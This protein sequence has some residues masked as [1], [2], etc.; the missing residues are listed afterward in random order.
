MSLLGDIFGVIAN[1]IGSIASSLISGLSGSSA[2]ASANE[3]NL[4]AARETNEA[5]KEIHAA[6][7]AFNAEQ[8]QIA[9]EWD[10]PAAKRKRLEEAGYNPMTFGEAANSGVSA[11]S[12]SAIP[13]TTGAPVQPVTAMSNALGNMNLDISGGLNA[14]KEREQ[15]SSNIESQRLERKLAL[16]DNI[17]KWTEVYNRAENDSIQ[18]K[19]A[20]VQV[21]RN[22]R[23]MKYLERR[24]ESNIR[25]LD[26][27]YGLKIE[28]IQNEKVSR[29]V[30]KLQIP[31][32]Q[33]AIQVNYAQVKSLIAQAYQA[34]QQG[35]AAKAQK[36][37]TQSLTK[38][39]DA[40]RDGKVKDQILK[41]GYAAII[42]QNA[43]ADLEY[44]ERPIF[45]DYDFSNWTHRDTQHFIDLLRN[46][47][48]SINPLGGAASSAVSTGA[49]LLK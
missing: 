35:D 1:P 21:E 29:E 19:L 25:L 18:R 26:A 44:N 42:Y 37:L 2:Q 30:A 4:Q 5:N 23:E 12:A 43:A 7:N 6:D 13:M 40:L 22:Q 11:S 8:A 28:Q 41:N 36:L 49:M 39:E 46:T 31:L 17:R 24:E 15:V 32:T 38:T 45:S 20:Q 9:R 27:E 10:T 16:E 33:A 3:A 34:Y 47:L 14:L 48:Q